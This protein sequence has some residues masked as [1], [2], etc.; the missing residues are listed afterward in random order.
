MLKLLARFARP[1]SGQLLAVIALQALTVGALLF[2]PALN[3]KI[4]DDGVAT[5][6]T[7]T[8]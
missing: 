3:A 8:I 6:A 1:Y 7:G 5:G 2:L 4:I